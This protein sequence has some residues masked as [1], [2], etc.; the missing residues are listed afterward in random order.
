MESTDLDAQL[1]IALEAALETGRGDRRELKLHLAALQ[2]DVGHAEKAYDHCR[3]ILDDAPDDLEALDLAAR[4]SAALD[5]PERTRRYR[6]VL[7]ALGDS[8]AT[9]PQTPRRA[10]VIPLRLIPG[11]RDDEEDPRR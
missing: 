1:I 2:I 9:K 7:R 10:R 5:D 4:A 11:G 6:R 3:Q 8:R